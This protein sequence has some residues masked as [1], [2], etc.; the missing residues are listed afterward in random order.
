[1]KILQDEIQSPFFIEISNVLAYKSSLFFMP[2]I[3]RRKVSNCAYFRHR[4]DFKFFFATF[5][6]T[7]KSPRDTRSGCL[8]W[9]FNNI[10][11]VLLSLHQELY[12]F[13]LHMR[14]QPSAW[15]LLVRNDRRHL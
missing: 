8:L 13:R 4:H 11:G 1:M 12:S 14:S 10:S 3:A 7:V 15:R 6:R 5:Q 2:H 9:R